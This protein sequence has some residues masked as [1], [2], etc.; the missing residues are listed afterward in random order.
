[1]KFR[2][3]RPN[4]VHEQHLFVEQ[5]II[6]VSLRRKLNVGGKLN[7]TVEQFYDSHKV[8]QQSNSAQKMDYF[9]SS[10]WLAK[11]IL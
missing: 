3:L 6:C 8:I 1:M 7:Q 11:L 5:N 10:N 2:S 9:V 4:T